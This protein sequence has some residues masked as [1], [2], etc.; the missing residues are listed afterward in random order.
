LRLL[1]GTPGQHFPS[2]AEGLRGHRGR[3]QL[4]VVCS[5]LGE[6]EEAEGLWLAALR[7]APGSLPAWQRL[8]G[9]YLD[10]G[11][12]EDFEAAVAE[13]ERLPGGEAEAA[14]R[15]ARALFVAPPGR[16]AGGGGGRPSALARQ[17]ALASAPQPR[18]A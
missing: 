2:V 6:R 3:H 7:E 13:I 11:R 10:W 12:R 17:R 16:G 8:A 15:R 4:A 18:A 14:W 5:R 9:Q 1:G